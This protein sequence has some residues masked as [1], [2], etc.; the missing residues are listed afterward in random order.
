MQ[1]CYIKKY[2]QILRFR[3]FKSFLTLDR[4]LSLYSWL[5]NNEFL[6]SVHNAEC[7][8]CKI[9]DSAYLE[10]HVETQKSKICFYC[11]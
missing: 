10:K 6:S 9:A 3:T 7:K 2:R 8:I 11:Y 1:Q 5:C 4:V